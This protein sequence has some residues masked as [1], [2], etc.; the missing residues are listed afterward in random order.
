MNGRGT[1]GEL[2]KLLFFVINLPKLSF[3]EVTIT[4]YYQGVFNQI[5]DNI[6]LK[7]I[8]L[9]KSNRLREKSLASFLRLWFSSINQCHLN[10]SVLNNCAHPLIE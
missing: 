7:I 3:T 4:R 10:V 8:K 6:R 1:V 5:L 2:F 9:R